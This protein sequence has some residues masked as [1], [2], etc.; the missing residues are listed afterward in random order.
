MSCTELVSNGNASEA[1]TAQA[2][3]AEPGNVQVPEVT[4][5]GVGDLE[6]LMRSPSRFVKP[7]W[8]HWNK[9]KRG[10]LEG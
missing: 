6:F 1:A 3:Q 5:R 8:R 10:P 9:K 2:R 4:L 7:G